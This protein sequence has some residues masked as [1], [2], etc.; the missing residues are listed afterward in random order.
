[1]K[2]AEL[3][4]SIIKKL[5]VATKGYALPLINQLIDEYG[6][7]P[8][9][10]LIGCLLSLRARDS[11]T[12]H[13]CRDLFAQAQTPQEILAIPLHTLERIIF[14]TVFYRNKA[15]TLHHVSS[16]LINRFDGHVPKTREELLSITGVGPKTANLVMGM[17]FGTPEI[18]VDTHVHRISNRLGLVKTKTVEETEEALKKVLPKKHWIEW[19]TLLVMWGQNLC[20]PL[21]PRCSECPIRAYCKQVG[22]TKFR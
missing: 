22:V 16:V 11:T 4:E 19:N 5:R 18:C 2:Q 9:L 10:I 17:A 13:V 3:I 15:L 7:K 14:K 12:I 8:F 21:S 6:H 20:T 1:M